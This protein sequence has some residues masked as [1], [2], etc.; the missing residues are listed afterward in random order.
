M[1]EFITQILNQVSVEQI[2]I[3]LLALVE[4]EDRRADGSTKTRFENKFVRDATSERFSGSASGIKKLIKMSRE[5]ILLLNTL[6]KLALIDD[7][8]DPQFTELS[9]GVGLERRST[10]ALDWTSK[11]CFY[12]RQLRC[13]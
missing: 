2:C 10:S 1:L 9:H 11:K 13:V 6:V 12:I 4:V 8:Q 5:A 3:K 7:S